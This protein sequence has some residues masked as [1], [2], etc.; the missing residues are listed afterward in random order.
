MLVHFQKLLK[1][2]G[3][4]GLVCAGCALLT[5]MVVVVANVLGR[6]ALNKPITGTVEIVGLSGVIL[7]SIALIYT[8]VKRGHIIISV[9]IDKLPQRVQAIL[10]KGT[11]L[12]SLGAVALLVWGG[13]LTASERLKE[14]TTILHLSAVPFRSIWIACCVVLGGI[15]LK[16]LSEQ[17]RARDTKK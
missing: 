3:M 15:L 13:V 12:F 7:I 17:F 5:M 9:A 8:E 4:G 14:W 6:F 16:H 10:R 11:I 1:L 2:A